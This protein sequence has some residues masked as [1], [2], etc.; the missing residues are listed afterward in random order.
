MKKLSVLFAAVIMVVSVSMAKAQK[1]ATVDLMGVLN[2]MPEKKKADTDIKAF[3]DVKQAEIKKKTDAAQA[4]FQQY[5]AEAPKKTAD[6][7]TAREAEM[8][9]LGDEIQQMQE[10]AQKDLQAKQDVAF[11]PIEKKLNDAIEKVAKANGYEFI[12]D[13]NAGALVYKAGADAT[14]AVKKELGIN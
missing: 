12:M 2:A 14:A 1:L 7:N 10:K 13:A 6:E 11:G 8:K 4:K 9:K 3:L 5:Q